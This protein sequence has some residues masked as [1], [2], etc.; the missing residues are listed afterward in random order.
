MIASE[1]RVITAADI[2]WE[3]PTPT[4]PQPTDVA[5]A[6]EMAFQEA[7]AYRLLAR[8]ALHALHTATIER[9]ILRG[10]RTLDR[11]NERAARGR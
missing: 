3:L 4:V 6:L 8:Q 5:E 10:Q 9:D 1:P 11:I 2:P 7:A